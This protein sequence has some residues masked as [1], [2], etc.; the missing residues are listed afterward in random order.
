MCDANRIGSQWQACRCR[1]VQCR[2]YPD[3]PPSHSLS[4]RQAPA[5]LSEARAGHCH[6]TAAVTGSGLKLEDPEDEDRDSDIS[7]AI[8][9]RWLVSRT[10][11]AGLA[12]VLQD[13]SLTCQL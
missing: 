10:D 4:H 7:D 6:C 3:P 13:G 11:L 8:S 1:K 12:A 5:S 9:A 2:F